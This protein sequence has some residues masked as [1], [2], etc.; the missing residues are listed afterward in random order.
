MNFIITLIA[1]V[2]ILGITVLIH[3]TGHFFFAKRAGI[4]VYEFSIGMGPKIFSFKRP[5]DE[6][7][8]CIRL[9]PIGGYVSMAGE[10]VEVDE[11]I[12]VEKRMQSKTWMQKFLTVIA[13]VMMNFILA[14]TLFFVIALVDGNTTLKPIVGV[15][16]NNTAASK[17]NLKKGDE[18]LS[19]N[20]KKIL[21]S[22]H[23]ILELQVNGS[24]EA[25]LKVEH[26]DGKVETIKIKPEK[27]KDK[28]GNVVYK[29]GFGLDGTK[30][31][32]V[33][34]SISY[35]LTKTVTL[36]HQMVLIIFYLCT[37]VLS[38]NNLSG[39]V[40]IFNLVGQ[41]AAAG[42]LNLIYLTA[43][44]SINVGF[45]NLL[46]LPAFDGGRLLFM[47]IEK[48][49]GSPVDSKIENWI[50]SIGFILLMVLMLFITYNDIVRLFH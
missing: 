15:V 28:E 41:S 47:V 35:A 16:E 27:E 9:F 17:V 21:S 34:S 8:Y 29:Y 22:D 19:I 14:I 20:G 42:I 7:N 2:I 23:F 49:K 13:G 32:G 4:Y 24:R 12:P 1:F 48:I 37:G 38:L 5:N 44:L 10:E 36:L 46:P 39:P 25:K 43:Y 33:L 30:H 6:T 31:Y 40:G 11:S 45:I 26:K 3:E 50:H 18:I